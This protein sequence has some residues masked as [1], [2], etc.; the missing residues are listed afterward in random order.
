MKEVAWDT[1]K[2]IFVH[3]VQRL[4]YS[5]DFPSEEVSQTKLLLK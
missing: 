4:F 2:K 1:A 3:S 5:K